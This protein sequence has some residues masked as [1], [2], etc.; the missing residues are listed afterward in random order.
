MLFTLFNKSTNKPLKIPHIGT[1]TTNSQEEAEEMLDAC[2]EY[3]DA[4]N[5][6]NL[7]DDI[8]IIDAKS[9]ND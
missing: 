9:L 7:K 4:I 3:L 6:K 8:I 2:L 1:W 5:A